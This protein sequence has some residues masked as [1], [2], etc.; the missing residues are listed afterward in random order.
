MDV[1][2]NLPKVRSSFKYGVDLDVCFVD[3]PS[4]ELNLDG[5]RNGFFT[6]AKKTVDGEGGVEREIRLIVVRDRGLKEVIKF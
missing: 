5:L 4:Y 2:E 1:S 3:Y 6:A